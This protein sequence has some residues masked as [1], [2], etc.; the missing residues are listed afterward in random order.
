VCSNHTADRLAGAMVHPVKKPDPRFFSVG[1]ARLGVEPGSVVFVD[2]VP[3]HV[4]A[5]RALGM[6]GVLHTNNSGRSAR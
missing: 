5:A 4:E 1:C 3:G 2:D 6:S